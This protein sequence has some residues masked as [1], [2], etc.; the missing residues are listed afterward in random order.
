MELREN[1]AILKKKNQR[2]QILSH[3]RFLNILYLWTFNDLEKYI[4]L[5]LFRERGSIEITKF[6]HILQ[7]RSVFFTSVPKFYLICAF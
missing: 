3:L 6:I 2:P 4:L 5:G 7:L 1:V